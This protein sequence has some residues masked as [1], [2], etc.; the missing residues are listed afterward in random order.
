MVNFGWSY[1]AGVNDNDLPGNSRA[2]L[3]AEALSYVI[4]ELL[5]E[6]TPDEV[7][8]KIIALWHDA[9]NGGYQQALADADEAASCK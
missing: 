4:Y 6:D 1:P 2:D 3:E 8:N 5:G 9:F 7:I